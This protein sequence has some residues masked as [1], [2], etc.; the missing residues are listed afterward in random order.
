MIYLINVLHPYSQL[1]Y[2]TKI[3][4]AFIYVDLYLNLVYSAIYYTTYPTSYNYQWA[5]L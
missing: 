4:N 3:K 5:P 1:K 2:E